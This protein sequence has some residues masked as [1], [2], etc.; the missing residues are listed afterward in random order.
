MAKSSFEI[1]LPRSNL[2]PMKINDSTL[3]DSTLSE[4][5]M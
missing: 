1:C 3:N 2:S 5:R 4:Q